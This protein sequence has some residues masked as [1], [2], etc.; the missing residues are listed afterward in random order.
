MRMPAVAL[1]WLVMLPAALAAA[2]DTPDY[3]TLIP[4]ATP[5]DR[6]PDGNTAVFEDQHGLIV[7]D[8]GRH[9]EHQAAILSLARG[10][11][12]PV[13]VMINSH[14]HLDHSGGNRVLREA[15]P[16]ATLYASG[17]VR[18]ALEGFLARSRSQ[19]QALLADPKF[20]DSRR[21]DLELDLAAIEDPN[22]LIPDHEV[23]GATALAFRGRALELHVATHAATA[24][25]TWLY[26]PQSHTLVAGDLVV[27][28]VPFFDTACANGWRRALG[29]LAAQPFVR[30]YP[31]HGPLL[32]RN[33]FDTYRRAFDRLVACSRSE[34]A[35]DR[36]VDGWLAD[37][38]P[39]LPGEPDRKMARAYLAYYIDNVV[40][41]A[42]KQREFCGDAA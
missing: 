1:P 35:R 13:T 18:D 16:K 7:F 3:L 5:E 20:P 9:P 10:R 14:W 11:G 12:K 15:Y 25:D 26:D 2:A 41:D 22:D 31:G 30:L 23:T 17:A 21:A 27:L 37:A 8:T 6:S 42:G 36:C 19:N 4:G 40:R 33:E 38:A 28:P 39:L 34:A 29:D 24:G 32:S